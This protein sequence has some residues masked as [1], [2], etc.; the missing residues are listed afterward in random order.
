MQMH[1]AFCIFKVQISIEHQL[2]ASHGCWVSR[3]QGYEQTLVGK[4]TKVLP[5]QSVVPI[6]EGP[7]LRN[8]LKKQF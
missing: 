3:T 1:K 7:T 2:S 6:G 5:W 8:T 4:Q